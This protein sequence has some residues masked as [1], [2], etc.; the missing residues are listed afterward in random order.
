LGGVVI[1]T[2]DQEIKKR[3]SIAVIDGQQNFGSTNPEGSMKV[4]AFSVQQIFATAKPGYALDYWKI[5]GRI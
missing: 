2:S 4:N 5:M 3:L 1:R